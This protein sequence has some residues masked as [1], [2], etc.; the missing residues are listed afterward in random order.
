MS[1]APYH[2]LIPHDWVKLEQLIN[3]LF[4][5][6]NAD[7]TLSEIASNIS[8]GDSDLQVVADALSTETSDRQSAIKYI[9]DALSAEVVGNAS[10]LVY[11]SDSLS[12]TNSYIVYLS[13]AVS[14]AVSDI[15]AIQADI[16]ATAYGEV[17]AYETN[18]T[19]TISGTGI[20]NKVQVTAF[21]VN[22]PSN[23]TTPDHTSD[24]IVVG[25]TGT[26]LIDV[27]LT[28]SSAMAG[29]ADDIGA[30]VFKNNGATQLQNLHANRTLAGGG[31][32]NGSIGMSGLA[33]LTLN[34]T[35][36]VWIWNYDSTDDIV[37]DDINLRIVQIVSA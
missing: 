14:D 12:N 29:G 33:A 32:D 35:V 21:T 27:S 30:G 15:T 2:P 8:V 28:I 34:D 1:P 3:E 10:D 4:S 26:Y 31:V 25:R 22:G 19:I 13:D 6:L 5:I 18:T 36:E 11:L 23:N 7:T 24:H 20:A 17:Y 9:S 16:D 37:V